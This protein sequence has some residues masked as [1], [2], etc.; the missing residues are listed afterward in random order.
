MAILTKDYQLL[1]QILLGRTNYGNVYVRVYAKYNSQ[2]IANNT[3]NVSVQGRLYNENS[4]WASSGTYYNISTEGLTSGNVNCNK[5][6]SNPWKTGEVILGTVTGDV[7]H[8][9]VGKKTI[10]AKARFVS[11]PWGW[12]GT[13]SA[14]VDLPTIPRQANIES[15]PNFNDEENP[16]ITY[17]N[18]AGNNVTTLQ[19]CISLD[20]T[21]D[22][23]K[24][25]DIDKNGTSYTFN[26]TEAERKILRSATSS[27]SRNVKFFIKTIL[28]ENTF[29]S[30][31]DK[32][33]TIINGNP[34][35]NNFEY[36][37]T[38]SKVVSVTG[39]NQVLVKGLSTLQAVITSTNKM[40]AKKQSTPKNYS[41]AIE[42]ISKNVNYSENDIVVDLG[43][44]L[45][46]GTKRLN[47]RAYDSRSNSTLVYKDIIVYEYEK[48]V[49]NASVTRL[50]N[51]ENQTT[52]KVSGTYSKL[53]INNVNKNSVNIIQY[54]YREVKGT[55]T[56]WE[57][58][59]VTIADGKFT[60]DDVILSL[61]NT[62]EFEIEIQ[63]VDNLDSNNVSLPLDIGQAIFFISS[64]KRACYINGQEILTYD[65]IDEW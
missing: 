40:I 24:Y 44:I 29:Y 59:V 30:I 18:P 16:K 1:K 19:A 65:I 62:K 43:N 15:A 45:S 4:W 54:R 42:N 33:F 32:T 6:S 21:S 11:S 61:D 7:K 55:W 58:M 23:I 25:R 35:F 13:A 31:V 37:D 39:S 64:N 51:F 20:G 28:G 38:N 36:K 14:N 5:N 34:E 26:L 57:N 12:D 22:D 50:N 56:A 63:A 17:K 10:S 8:D 3:S 47:I 9:N 49:I 41:L 53:T 46:S 27:N 60:C 48:P 52:I 2:S